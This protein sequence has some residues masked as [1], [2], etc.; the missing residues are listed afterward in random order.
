MG[1]FTGAGLRYLITEIPIFAS[2]A[3]PLSTFL[4]NVTGAFAVGFI[5]EFAAHSRGISPFVVLFLK[6]G[7]CGGFTT[8]S[9]LLLE[10]ADMLLDGKT[11]TCLF[12]T[13]SSLILG[14]CA[15]FASRYVFRLFFV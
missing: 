12:Y 15:I 7:L 6:I 14:V 2:V 13:L 8:F 1:G 4:I 10:G 11:S 3:F 5:T 9:A